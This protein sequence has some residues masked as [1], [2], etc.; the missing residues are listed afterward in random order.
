MKFRISRDCDYVN[1]H[2]RYGH[3]EGIVEADNLEDLKEKIKDYPNN[4]MDLIVDDYEVDDY[5]CGDN[6]IEIEEI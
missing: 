1:G 4:Y 5:D 6:E 3:L 2:L